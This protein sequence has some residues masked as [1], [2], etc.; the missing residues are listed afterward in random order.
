MLAVVI[1]ARNEAGR[2]QVLIRQVL[3]AGTG[4]AL[5]VANGCTDG[6]A[7]LVRRMGDSRVKTLVYPEALGYDVPRIAG[8]RAALSLG[9]DGVLFVDG[10]LGGQLASSLHIILERMR[11]GRIDL[12]LTDCY[13]A[14]PI[15]YR[16]SAAAE[17]YQS[18]VA[19]NE[20]LGRADLRAAIPSHG[21]SAVSRRLLERLPQAV[22][23]VPP[24]MQAHACRAGLAVEVVAT[25]P[26]RQLGS[27]KRGA[28]HGRLIADTII[29]DCR[30]G[31]CHAQGRNLDRGGFIGYHHQRR[32]DLLG[33]LPPEEDGINRDM[34]RNG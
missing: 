26:H 15:P 32:F 3:Q 33:L 17:V 7:E 8:A 34:L 6:T 22:L 29:G 25:L 21:P 5:V 13:A 20:A 1:P 30:Q 24:L 31:I 11:R 2:I 19:L 18:R 16:Q 9:A 27:A 23:G 12:L 4:L 10:D 14:T 28:E